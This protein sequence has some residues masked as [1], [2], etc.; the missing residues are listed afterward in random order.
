MLNTRQCK[1]ATYS[2]VL[3]CRGGVELAEGDDI[4]LDFH[5][6]GVVLRG[7]TGNIATTLKEVE[8][9]MIHQ[10]VVRENWTE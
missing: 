6:V 5:E 10:M 7:P 3:N 4:F 1:S 2:F 9:L 8:K